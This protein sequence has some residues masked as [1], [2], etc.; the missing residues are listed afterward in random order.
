MRTDMGELSIK[1]V[2]R[3]ARARF[4]LEQR[5]KIGRA[6]MQIGAQLFHRQVALMDKIEYRKARTISESQQ[7]RC[8]TLSASLTTLA[9]GIS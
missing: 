4:P 8:T 3:E 2:S 7:I 1:D 6:Q 5:G 9:R